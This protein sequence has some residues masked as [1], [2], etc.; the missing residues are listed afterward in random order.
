MSKSRKDAKNNITALSPQIFNHL[1]KLFVFN[2]PQNKNHWINE[3]DNWLNQIDEIYLKPTNKKPDW[4]TIYNWLVFDSAPHYSPEF[5]DLKVRKWKKS[6]YKSAMV[7]DYDGTVVLNQILKIL[8]KVSK[9]IA[10]DKFVT[11]QDYMEI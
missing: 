6:E 9:D 7:Y 2:D 5:I 1:L 8:E 4:Q 11:A 3:I 10:G